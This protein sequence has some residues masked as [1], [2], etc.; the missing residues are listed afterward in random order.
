MREANNRGEEGVGAQGGGVSL[1]GG[2]GL[3]EFEF[4]NFKGNVSPGL[5][6]EIRP[7]YT[8]NMDSGKIGIL[9][10]LQKVFNTDFTFCICEMQ[11]RSYPRSS[12]KLTSSAWNYGRGS[13][14]ARRESF[15]AGERA[16]CL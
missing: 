15:T 14:P 13:E 16:R 9:L 11:W 1:S 12:R 5:Q 4:F 10:L 2:G 7:L 8:S 6:L 3:K